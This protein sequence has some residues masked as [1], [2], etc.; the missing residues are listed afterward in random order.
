[1]RILIFGAGSSMGVEYPS[2]DALIPAVGRFVEEY[3]DPILK[4]YWQR[5]DSWRTNSELPKRIVF[6]PNPEVV[7]SLPD[8]YEA[9]TKA[10]DEA[11]MHEVLEKYR[12]GN[13]TEEELRNHE[14]YYKSEERKRLEEARRARIGLACTPKTPP[15]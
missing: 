2:A 7:L 10:A 3:S 14:E 4:A 12:A 1:M 15:K 8:L 5:W 13:L 11:E 9:A 6:N